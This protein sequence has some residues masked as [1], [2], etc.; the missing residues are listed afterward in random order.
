MVYEWKG[1]KYAINA[2]VVGKE[3]ERLEQEQG[4]V[5]AK[6]LVDAARPKD[7]ALHKLFEWDNTKAAEMYRKQQAVQVLCALAVVREDMKEPTTVRAYM[8]VADEAD[9]PTRRT[10]TFI[11]TDAAF[12]DPEKRAMILRVAVR[13]LKE[14]RQ[15][16]DA[17]TELAEVFEAIDRLD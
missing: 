13:D 1:R 10:G 15:R 17:L 7:S 11:N 3:V 14:I 16:Y 5:T 9:N 2:N 12:T 8:N 4:E 6:G